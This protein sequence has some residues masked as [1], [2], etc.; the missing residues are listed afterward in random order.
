LVYLH[1][2]DSFSLQREYPALLSVSFPKCRCTMHFCIEMHGHPRSLINV[3]CSSS[4]YSITFVKTKSSHGL[5]NNVE[6][7]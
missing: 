4:F 5:N 3:T 6:A 7:E 1:S 2:S